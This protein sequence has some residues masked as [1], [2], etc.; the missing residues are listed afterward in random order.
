MDE[1]KEAL[2]PELEDLV[3]KF[4]ELLTGEATPER[5]EMVKV[6]CLYTT[7]AKAMP[8]L[9]QHWGSEPEHMEARN[10]IREIIEQIKLWNQEKNQKH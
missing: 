7:M 10:Q 1:K 3:R 9:I 8:P 6:W 5:V 2:V 4:T